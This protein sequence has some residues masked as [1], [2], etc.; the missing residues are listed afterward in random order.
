[1]KTHIVMVG[2]LTVIL[3][4]ISCS[5]DDPYCCTSNDQCVPVHNKPSSCTTAACGQCTLVDPLTINSAAWPSAIVGGTYE[6]PLA[7]SG[8]IPPYTWEVTRGDETTLDWLTIVWIGADNTE[9]ALQNKSGEY[10]VIPTAGVS[11]TVTVIDS[12]RHG[13]DLRI[14]NQGATMTQMFVINDCPHPCQGTGTHCASGILYNC[15]PNP[16]LPVS[17]CTQWDGGAACPS[18]ACDGG[19]LNCCPVDGSCPSVAAT[20]CQVNSADNNAYIFGCSADVNGCLVW[21]TT[22]TLCPR[23]NN[24]CSSDGTTCGSAVVI[25]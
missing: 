18:G 11:L 10:P 13:T 7:A 5:S 1:M 3:T 2:V 6:V 17:S 4:I 15:E 12:S 8:G 20:K 24:Y 19:E 22:G 23:F 14:D 16:A 21:N 9:A 25:K